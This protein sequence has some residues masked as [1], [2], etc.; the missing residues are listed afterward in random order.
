MA[1]YEFLSSN[2]SSSLLLGNLD[3]TS[4][5]S[6]AGAEQIIAVLQTMEPR[7][8]G[9]WLVE[10]SHKLLELDEHSQLTLGMAALCILSAISGCKPWEAMG[11]RRPD[12]EK[13]AATE[14][15]NKLALAHYYT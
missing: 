2:P 8:G 7:H 6:P 11:I 15:L 5:S 13:M 10:I 14:K 4:L 9:E 12:F 1:P 3:L